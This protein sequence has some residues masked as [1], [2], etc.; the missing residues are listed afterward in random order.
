MDGAQT[1]KYENIYGTK[2][3][4]TLESVISDLYR[5]AG[6]DPSDVHSACFAVAGP[7]ANDACAMTNVSWVIDGAK[8]EK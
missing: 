1:L 3:H 7:V 5:D 2:G 6:V 4:E 8:L